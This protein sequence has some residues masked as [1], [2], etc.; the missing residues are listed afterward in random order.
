ME[1]SRIA[2]AENSAINRGFRKGWGDAGSEWFMTRFL[3]S[4]K[5]A[6]PMVTGLPWKHSFTYEIAIKSAENRP[7]ILRFGFFARFQSL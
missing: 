6:N 1:A 5:S 4:V 2:R 7:M 3:N